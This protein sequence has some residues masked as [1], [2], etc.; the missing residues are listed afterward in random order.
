M[1]SQ[2][3]L[4]SRIHTPLG[5][6]ELQ[7]LC[8]KKMA[9][10]LTRATDRWRYAYWQWTRCLWDVQEAETCKSEAQARSGPAMYL[11]IVTCDG[12]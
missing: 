4:G 2:T 5:L 6:V 10:F 12:A 3:Y 1:D 8:K 7:S 11:D 9:R